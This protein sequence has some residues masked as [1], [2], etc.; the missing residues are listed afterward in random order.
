MV[1]SAAGVERRGAVRATVAAFEI[2]ADAQ[3]GPARAA[4]NG[5]RGPFR[6]WP[7]LD[8]MAGER[9]VAVL[10]GVVDAAAA[11]LDR[12]D[13]ERRAPVDAAGFRV[14]TEAAHRGAG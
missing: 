6:A 10:A 11:H 2:G 4:E 3:L 5:G 1:G 13:V 9:R 7:H 8:R 14:Q 12:H